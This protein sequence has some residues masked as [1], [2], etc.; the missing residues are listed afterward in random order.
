MNAPTLY[1]LC[2]VLIY[3]SEYM[4]MYVMDTMLAI[5]VHV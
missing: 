4:Y 3:I 5:H 2:T 1:N